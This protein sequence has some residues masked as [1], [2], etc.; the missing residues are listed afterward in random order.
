MWVESHAMFMDHQVVV[1]WI[2]KRQYI[3]L[4]CTICASMHALSTYSSS[5]YTLSLLSYHMYDA[6]SSV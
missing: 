5:L 3:Y 1:D 2:E 4:A 6:L